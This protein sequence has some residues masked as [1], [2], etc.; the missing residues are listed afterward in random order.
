[1]PPRPTTSRCSMTR[2][3]SGLGH[4]ITPPTSSS[5]RDPNS[6]NA[7]PTSVVVSTRSRR[8]WRPSLDAALR[9]LIVEDESPI[10]RLLEAWVL[11]EGAHAV[12]AGSAE[13]ALALMQA[14]GP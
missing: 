7:S 1:M 12:T 13:E 8:G 10:R 4:R 6:A 9:V 5:T 11:A 3:A 2:Q 14:E